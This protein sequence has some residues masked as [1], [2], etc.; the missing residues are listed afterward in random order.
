MAPTESTTRL[1]ERA[2]GGVP[3]ALDAL[4]ARCVGPLER[5]ARGRLPD[6]AR[7]LADT[8]DLVQDALAACLRQ[9]LLNRLREEI[10]RAKRRPPQTLL[11]GQP[12]CVPWVQ[13]AA[14]CMP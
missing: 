6:W 2:R 3:A 1:L 10:R 5:W 4:F 13:D 7:S 8:Q 9:A 12:G 11:E 14:G